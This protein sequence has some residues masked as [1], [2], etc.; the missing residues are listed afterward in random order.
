MQPSKGGMKD[1]PPG[2]SAGRTGK[3]G[4]GLLVL[5]LALGSGL[6][7][8]AATDLRWLAPVQLL[9]A[10]AEV[11]AGVLIV[12]GLWT[13]IASTLACALMA[14]S[15]LL[16]QWS[17]VQLVL[18]AIAASLALLGPGA[19]SIDARLFGRRRVEIKQGFGD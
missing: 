19:W 14:G 7:A 12:I 8:S 17:G 10:V 13:P 18:G 6:F 5:R 2:P 9:Q 15:V 1:N 16:A 4:A 11:L 3:L